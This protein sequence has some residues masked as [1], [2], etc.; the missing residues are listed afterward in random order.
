M[1]LKVGSSIRVSL[2]D[3]AVID[4]MGAT[5]IFLDVLGRL[6]TITATDFEPK[7]I[8]QIWLHRYD[9]MD[10]LYPPMERLL[11][12]RYLIYRLEEPLRLLT[13]LRTSALFGAKGT[14]FP[15]QTCSARGQ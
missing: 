14:T 9:L 1:R 6:S 11:H 15:G 10:F 12:L 8:R 4:R 2:G 13:G 3:R 7:K 5:S